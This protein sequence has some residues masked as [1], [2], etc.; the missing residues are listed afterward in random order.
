MKDLKKH[1]A[2]FSAG[3]RA[4]SY[5]EVLNGSLLAYR[6]LE[7][8]RRQGVEWVREGDICG[9]ATGPEHD[10]TCEALEATR[11]QVYEKSGISGNGDFRDRLLGQYD[12]QVGALHEHLLGLGRK[13]AA[14]RVATLLI[15]QIAAPGGGV[16]P[17]PM[18]RR[19][20]A[21]VQMPMSRSEM[22][23]YLGLTIETVCRTLADMK[24]HKLI[25]I[26][27]KRGE[28]EIVSV[29]GLCHAAKTDVCMQ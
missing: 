23:D 18:G 26:G 25:D 14:E 2:L 20:G 7:D 1:D 13:T 17:V 5:Y 28:I 6:A 10:S 8:G 22:A 3:D 4:A 29:C 12:R 16:C 9:F 21:V 27:E 19:G 24:R 15:R 11:V